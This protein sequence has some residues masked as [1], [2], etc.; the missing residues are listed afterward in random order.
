MQLE[1][2]SNYMISYVMK[3]VLHVDL[4]VTSWLLWE[5]ILTKVGDAH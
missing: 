5:M 3:S 1:S 2:F 4:V